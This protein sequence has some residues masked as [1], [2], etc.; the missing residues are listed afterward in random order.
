MNGLHVNW[1]LNVAESKRNEPDARRFVYVRDLEDTEADMMF[2]LDQSLATRFFGDLTDKNK[3]AGV[4]FLLKPFENPSLPSVK[5]GVLYDKKDR[6][7]S[8]RTFG[9]K[10]IPGGNF[11]KNS[12]F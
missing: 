10:N 4:D 7:F 8:A 5:F 1:N 11:S 12:K 2:L 3:G 6:T 9:F